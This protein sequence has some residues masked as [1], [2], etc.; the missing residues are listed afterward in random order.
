MRSFQNGIEMP[1]ISFLALELVGF[2]VEN[3]L[4]IFTAGRFARENGDSRLTLERNRHAV[5]RSAARLCRSRGEQQEQ[6]GGKTN[7]PMPLAPECLI[8]DLG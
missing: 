6:R 5:H 7:P 2:G 3:K 8:H 4:A 1:V